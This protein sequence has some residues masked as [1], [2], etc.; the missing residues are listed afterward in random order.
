M[1]RRSNS[2]YYSRYEDRWPAYVPVAERR[3]KAELEMA[4]L[5]KK[6]VTVSP[7]K[8]EGRVIASTF[9]GKAW[10]ENLESYGDYANRIERGRTYVRNG[11]VVDLQIAPR[12]VMATVSGS[13]LYKVKIS[14]GEVAKTQW[15]S[16]CTDCAGGIDSLVEL[17][18]GRFSKGVMERI[19]RQGVGLFPKPAEIRFSCSCPDYASMC[20]HV[21][22]VLYG[23][24]AR[25]DASPEMLFRL[26]AVNENDLVAEIGEALP[27]SKQGPV[28]G[29]VLE[30]DDMAALFGLDM[31]DPEDSVA[32][33][34]AVP[35]AKAGS[36]VSASGKDAKVQ[37]SSRGKIVSV[38][39]Q[40]APS[41]TKSA[42]PD[43]AVQKRV[44]RAGQREVVTEVVHN[45]NDEAAAPARAK[46]RAA[47]RNSAPARAKP[48]ARKAKTAQ[49]AGRASAE[50]V[51]QV[52]ATLP[53]S[54]AS[55]RSKPALPGKVVGNLAVARSPASLTAK[56]VANDRKTRRSAGSIP[57][58]PP[59]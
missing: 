33:S 15:K 23:V 45:R 19:C 58:A 31:A 37:D 57:T 47:T 51:G 36:R 21:A 40:P 7:V 32:A 26:R 42:A 22:A 29:K 18:Q 6:G 8:I 27:M 53:A 12:E 34:P 54:P 48:A 4:K 52:V 9:W 13:E 41:G 43:I 38:G 25:L 10:C 56:P 59:A 16:I 39:R 30:A 44:P 3:R 17:L 20:K 50:P 11:S 49:S 46:P 24:G 35:V 28:A 1:S 55:G 5:R 14:I 2:R